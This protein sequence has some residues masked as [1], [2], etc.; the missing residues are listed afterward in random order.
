LPVLTFDG[1]ILKKLVE[2][3]TILSR[4]AVPVGLAHEVVR[5]L[6]GVERSKNLD[7]A[8]NFRRMTSPLL[9]SR[10]IET[11]LE[12]KRKPTGIVTC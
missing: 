3:G 2:G 12:R 5:K 10:R 6:G 7:K 8:R 9:G 1:T 11:S 4:S